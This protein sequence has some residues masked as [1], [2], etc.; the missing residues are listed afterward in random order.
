LWKI[1][2]V[3]N[4]SWLKPYKESRKFPREEVA[5]PPAIVFEG[6][7]HFEVERILAMEMRGAKRKRT[8]WFL[9]KWQGWPDM[10]NLW[11]PKSELT[12]AKDA[13][14]DFMETRS[15]R[16]GIAIL[17]CPI[18]ISHPGHLHSASEC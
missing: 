11:L 14:K 5:L 17:S 4:V 12:N 7:E 15:W 16:S 1:H 6:Q 3:I 9:V 18:S 13:I 10:Y 8:Q 2:D